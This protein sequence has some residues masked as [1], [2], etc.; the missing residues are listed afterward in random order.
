MRP[1]SVFKQIAIS[2]VLIGVGLLGWL[3]RDRLLA[4]AMTAPAE[5]RRDA[6]ARRFRRRP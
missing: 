6:C 5:W 3:E 4:F 2:A 1:M